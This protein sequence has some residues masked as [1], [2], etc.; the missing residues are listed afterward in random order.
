MSASKHAILG[1]IQYMHK[2][3]SSD[4]ESVDSMNCSDDDDDHYQSHKNT[5][6]RN[7]EE[8]MLS[9]EDICLFLYQ[10]Q[11]NVVF[12]MGFKVTTGERFEKKR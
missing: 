12:D 9:K 1:T 6:S 8:V 10:L 3:A 2:P 7:K 11:Y 5:S 4:D